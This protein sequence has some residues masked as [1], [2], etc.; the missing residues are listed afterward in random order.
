MA[1]SCKEV[2]INGYKIQCP[3][4][5]GNRFWENNNINN[6]WSFILGLGNKKIQNFICQQCGHINWFWNE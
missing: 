6:K 2:I 4:C 5:G 1:K 3:I